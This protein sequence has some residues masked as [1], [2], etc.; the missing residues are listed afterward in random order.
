MKRKKNNKFLFIFLNISSINRNIIYQKKQ[1]F[2]SKKLFN[3][4]I[5]Y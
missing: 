5:K 1:N 4:K 2:K 3:L